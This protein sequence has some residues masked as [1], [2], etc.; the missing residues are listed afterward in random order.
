MQ[1]KWTVKGGEASLPSFLKK[2]P[3]EIAQLFL[4]RGIDT[5]EKLKQFLTPDFKKDLAD[6]FLMLGMRKGVA[7]IKKAIEQKEPITIFGDYDADGVCGAAI[8]ELTL[9]KLGGQVQSIYIPDRHKEGYGLNNKAVKE[10]AKEGTKLII[11]VDCGVTDVEEVNLAKNLGIDVVISDHHHV[12]PKVPK[13]VAIINPHQKKDK[14]PFKDLSGA[15]VAYKLCQALLDEF[16]VVGAETFLKWQLDLVALATVADCVSLMGENRTLVKFGL[17]VLAQTK[18]FGLRCLMKKANIKPVCDVKNLCTNLDSFSLGFLLAPRINAAGRMDHANTAY[19]LLM[20]QSKQEARWLAERLDDNNKKRQSETEKLIRKIEKNLQT[21]KEEVII[22]EGGAD[23]ASGIVGLVAGKVAEKYFKPAFIFGFEGDLVKG[24][25]RAPGNFNL[26]E[27]LE[28]GADL[29]VEFGG[30]PKAAGYSLKKENLNKFKAH[31]EQ[32]VKKQLKKLSSPE[33][34]I[35]VELKLK[36]NRDL[37][38]LWKYLEKFSPFGTDNQEPVFLT[39]G[40]TVL[41]VRMVGNGNGHLKL[42]LESSE[43]PGEI[44]NAIGFFMS[45]RQDEIK[46]GQKIDVVYRLLKDEW[47]GEKRLSLKLVDFKCE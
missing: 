27:M 8:L 41:N 33:L 1:K 6:P 19:E 14:Y 18:N 7:R 28:E 46:I 13:A 34:A 4:L 3:K 30:H 29:F 20:T 36:G 35:E 17:L 15:G 39:S 9:R 31:L 21:K 5:S 37:W 47:N 40:L 38:E 2:Y 23:F 45:E 16:K 11:T 12:W 24:S 22:F 26:I 44:F 10:I 42:E 43:K 32:A 25:A